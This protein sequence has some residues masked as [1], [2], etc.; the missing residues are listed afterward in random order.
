VLQE[1]Q[2]ADPTH[3]LA[4]TA[5]SNVLFN[6]EMERSATVEQM[7]EQPLTYWFE[8]SFD[9]FNGNYPIGFRFMAY[10]HAVYG[11]YTEWILRFKEMYPYQP[12]VQDGCSTKEQQIAVLKATYGDGVL[13]GFYPWIQEHESEFTY[14]LEQFDVRSADRVDWYPE[15]HAGGSY[16]YLERFSYCDLYIDLEPAKKYLSEYKGCDLSGLLLTAGQP[17]AVNLYREDGSY[18]SILL[19]EPVSLEG[20]CY[21]KLLGEGYLDVFEIVGFAEEME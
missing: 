1:L 2:K 9:H 4:Y 5:P 12:N 13:D 6:M 15:F 20:I 11:N 7:C 8:N 16:L 3:A 17:V 10:L 19:N 21:I 14:K 18:S